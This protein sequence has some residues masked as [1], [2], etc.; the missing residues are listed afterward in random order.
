MMPDTKRKIAVRQDIG[1]RRRFCGFGY[2]Q[3]RARALTLMEIIVS[4][5]IMAIIFAVIVP[6]FVTMRN[7]WDS[8]QA[9]A[10]TLQNGRVL[11]DHLNR[12]LSKAV[13][14][15][16]VSDS[17]ETDGYIQFLDNDSNSL[18]YEIVD[19]YVQFGVVGSLSDLAGPVSQLQFTCYDAND[20]NTPIVDVN[21]IRLVRVETTLTNSAPLGQDKTLIASVYLRTN[22]SSACD[23]NLVG[24]WKLDET[25]GLT[26]AD[27]S[28]YGNDGTLT[29]MVGDEWTTGQIGG[30]LAFDGDNDAITGIGNN[31][32]G[33]FTVAAWAKDTS[34]GDNWRVLYSAEQEIWF[35]VDNE[36]SPAIWI[37][38][39]GDGNGAQTAAG[40]W[41][42][43]T[44]HYIAGTFDGTTVHIYLDG[45]DMP[46]TVYGT[47]NNPKAKA[48]VIG[49]WSKKPSDENWGGAIDDVRIYN[50]ALSEEEISQLA[51]GGIRP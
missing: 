50:R 13:K 30:A 46:I 16:A 24:W 4:L 49:A 7:S 43:D 1:H 32:T 44:W 9:A 34:G 42:L 12:N 37:D 39:G 26:A 35:G 27:S 11:I 51:G 10:E 20:F 5:A 21:S 36:A 14:I 31:P 29:N 23:S 8:K 38:V 28:D 33:T 48:A 47:P 2:P 3:S 15:T 25:S 18:R 17:T 6:L 22:S 41:T 40:T 19:S 45:V